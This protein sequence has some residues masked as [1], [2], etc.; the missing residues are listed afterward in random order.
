MVLKCFFQIHQS[1]IQTNSDLSHQKSIRASTHLRKEIHKC[2]NF[3]LNEKQELE[4]FSGKNL[5]LKEISKLKGF[6]A[7]KSSDGRDFIGIGKV[8]NGGKI[9]LNFLPKE[10]CRKD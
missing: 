3:V 7:V 6:V 4:W 1:D 2:P 8:G 10:R 5:E 9:L